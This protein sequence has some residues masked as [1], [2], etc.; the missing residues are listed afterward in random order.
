MDTE[1]QRQHIVDTAV[2]LA[3]QRAAELMRI[4]KNPGRP[5]R[6]GVTSA[7]DDIG[8]IHRM[9][10]T[11]AIGLDIAVATDADP[12]EV[13]KSL[14]WSE[15]QDLF[16]P[17]EVNELVAH[18]PDLAKKLPTQKNVDDQLRACFTASRQML[19]KC[20]IE[21]RYTTPRGVENE[22][23]DADSAGFRKG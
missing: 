8:T 3:K 16:L 2:A 12:V 10:D 9:I 4:A 17:H 7:E 22:G 21:T 15:F 23:P 14:R 6:L 19:E 5:G 1:Q 11:L 18:I 20:L 13:L